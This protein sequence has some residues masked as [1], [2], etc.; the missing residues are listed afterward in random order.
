MTA[1]LL[2]EPNK[3]VSLAP[4]PL[5]C[6]AM[7]ASIGLY[8]IVGYVLGKNVTVGTVASVDEVMINTLLLVGV[9]P[10]LASPVVYRMLL[11]ASGKRLQGSDDLGRWKAA[12]FVATIVAYALREASAIVGLVL[13]LLTGQTMWVTAFGAL[14]IVGML[15]S[16]PD[17]GR[18]EAWREELD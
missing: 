7:L 9:A 1:P 6:I 8:I 15:L 5:I 11:R 18:F 17:R 14:A 2:V 16:F 3:R 4:L 13:T 10:S 12:F